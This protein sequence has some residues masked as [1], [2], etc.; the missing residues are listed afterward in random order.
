MTHPDFVG[1]E[2]NK[3]EW[4]GTRPI[5]R[6]RSGLNQHFIQK[7][8]AQYMKSLT[9]PDNWLAPYIL[10]KLSLPPFLQSIQHMHTLEEPSEINLNPFKK[11]LCFDEFLAHQLA[12]ILSSRKANTNHIT[13]DQPIT[14]SPTPLIC[15]LLETLPFELTDGQNK[16]IEEIL[17]DMQKP[18]PMVRLLQGDVGSGKTVVALITA[19]KQIEQGGQVVF[20]SP[21]EILSIQHYNTI[22]NFFGH[23]IRVQLLTGRQTAK[24]K[25]QI[26]EDLKNHKIDLLIGTHAIIQDPVV[27][28]NL[29]FCIV[30][31]QHRFGVKQRMLLQEKGNAVH[32][33]SMTATPIPRTLT[34]AQ[35]GDM[36]ISILKEKPKGRIPIITTLLSTAKY[37]ELIERLSAK[38][39]NDTQIYWVC[40]L[41]ENSETLTYTA[42]ETRYIALQKVFGENNVLIVHGK[43][44]SAQ[45]DDVMEKFKTGKAKILVSTTVIEVGVDVPNAS[46]MIIENAERFGLSQLHQLRGRVG[47]GQKE[48]YCVLLYGKAL[49]QIGKKRLEVMKSTNDGFEISEMD[50]KL[51]GQGEITGTQQSGM[52]SFKFANFDEASIQDQEIYSTLLEEANTYAWELFLNPEYKDFF[53]NACNYLLKIYQK[54]NAVLYTKTG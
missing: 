43:M 48:S 49:T 44:K 10:K 19:I 14:L 24:Q 29:T 1:T 50:L 2:K 6:L 54:D 41:I 18:F 35:Y 16:T 22:T 11:R 51:R 4:Q 23:K 30:D 36:D 46:I 15:E 52:P 13:N 7:F 33:L 39:K 26:Y 27:F 47:R 37:E 38:I 8:I 40:P 17:K 25:K 5:Y 28:K 32:L 9:V 34:L 53:D 20:L 3:K 45:K 12:L 42:A 21:T 31:E